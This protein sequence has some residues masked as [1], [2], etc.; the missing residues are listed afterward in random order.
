MSIAV[1]IISWNTRAYLRSCLLTVQSEGAAQVVV[2]DNGSTDGS[3]E[4][5]RD[6]FPQ[7]LLQ[8]NS[9]NVGYG[10]AANQALRACSTDHVLLLNSD[11][12]LLPGSLQALATY[13]DEHL[14]VG[15]AGP[16]IQNPDGSLQISCF[17]FPSPFYTLLWET[18]FGHLADLSPALRERY[19]PAWS[20]D[21]ARAVPWVLGAALAI[22]REAFNAIDGFDESFFMYS[23]EIDLA[24][25]LQLAGWHTHFAPDAAIVHVG[26]ASTV[27]RKLAMARQLVSSRV[28]FYRLH[29]APWQLVL[30]RVIMSYVML[31]N[32]AQDALQAGF[33]RQDQERAT[34]IRSLQ[35]WTG[36]LIA[37]VRGA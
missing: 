36:V 31:R 11:T 21:R 34:S 25:R 29:Y 4:M 33:G 3:I 12:L 15:M 6:E 9:T 23:E 5:I 30:L 17:H 27:Q 19:L 37:L 2:V 13:L 32:M 22:R 8:V 16:H 10:A 1:A 14:E 24:Y 20:H 18:S 7:V 26:G 35:M 28:H